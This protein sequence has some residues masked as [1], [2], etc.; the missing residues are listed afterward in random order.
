M[1]LRPI[2]Q[3]ARA[4]HLRGVLLALLAAVPLLAV[5]CGGGT[6]APS[7]TAA[8]FSWEGAFVT[9]PIAKPNA[10]LTDTSGKP[11]DLKK[12]TQGYV[13]LLYIGYLHC[14]DICPQHMS[15]L[16]QAFIKLPVDVTK[17]VRVVF[18]TAD[19]ERD[20]PDL[21]RK[22]LDS[23]NTGF[24]GLYGTQAQVDAFQVSLGLEPAKKTDLGDGNYA[25][26]HAAYVIAFGTDN[27]AHLV[28]PSGITVDTW[29]HDLPQLV[30]P[31]WKGS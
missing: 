2:P 6:S 23:F 14:P 5:A 1:S 24:I 7:P 11:F 29:V 17:H 25:V 19:P 20:K 10:V 15:D 12:D 30:Q 26:S 3:I 22:W 9:P 16:R 27:V 8:P 21:I 31:G 4:A 28:Y 18:V 13:T